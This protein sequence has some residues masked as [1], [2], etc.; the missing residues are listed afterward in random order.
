MQ[1]ATRQPL[2]NWDLMPQASDGNKYVYVEIQ[3]KAGII[4]DDPKKDSTL[5]EDA[6][7]EQIKKY[8]EEY[9]T[10]YFDKT[11]HDKILYLDEDS[12]DY[13]YFKK[14]YDFLLSLNSLERRVLREYTDKY[15]PLILQKFINNIGNKDIADKELG[16]YALIYED[17]GNSSVFNIPED[18]PY[19]NYEIARRFYETMINLFSRC[20][21]TEK[22]MRVFRGIKVD[23][24]K[25]DF[26]LRPFS[27]FVS[28][29]YSPK[30]LRGPFTERNLESGVRC[31]VMDIILKPGIPAIWMSPISHYTTFSWDFE[32]KY[33]RPLN[34]GNTECELL[35]FCDRVKTT[36]SERKNK[37]LSIYGE[38]IIFSTNDV[39]L[40]P[41]KSSQELRAKMMS[42]TPT[43]TNE[44]SAFKG[45]QQGTARRRRHI[46]KRKTYRKKSTK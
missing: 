13:S 11:L 43:T 30:K 7:L 36:Y 19:R 21:K 22:E 14:Q 28:T 20:P 1:N 34:T 29:T 23:K 46:R 38:E 37:K 44:S 8:D 24:T 6:N 27:G 9:L 3:H 5:Y 12:L 42:R 4:P 33:R 31:C 18:T 16:R 2:Y 35:L 40:E 45:S 17:L 25:S 39:I 26:D 10:I 41:I 32:Y 15:G